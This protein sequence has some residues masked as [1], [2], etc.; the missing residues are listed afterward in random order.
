MTLG[1]F[2]ELNRIYEILASGRIELAKTELETFLSLT[3]PSAPEA[4]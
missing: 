4:A 2:K 3:L 1:E